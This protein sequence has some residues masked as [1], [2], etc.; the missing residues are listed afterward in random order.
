MLRPIIHIP[1]CR[2]MTEPTQRFLVIPLSSIGDIVHALPA[3][4]ALGETFPRAEIYWAVETRYASLLE[5]NPFV[6]QVIK[7]NTIG[8]RR[9]FMPAETPED[10]A[11]SVLAL[12]EVRGCDGCGEH[13]AVA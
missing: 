1:P 6:H 12:R 13:R 3:V 9:K 11:R 7:L 10:I 4:A 8:W 2:K 5:G